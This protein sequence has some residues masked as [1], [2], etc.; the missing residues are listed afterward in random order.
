MLHTQRCAVVTTYG[1]I[2][3]GACANTKVRMLVSAIE[4]QTDI[5]KRGFED[6][7][8]MKKM[9]ADNMPKLVSQAKGKGGQ[10]KVALTKAEVGLAC[11]CALRTNFQHCLC[12]TLLCIP[13]A[14]HVQSCCCV[15]LYCI[16]V[17]CAESGL[18]GGSPSPPGLQRVPQHQPGEGRL[19]QAAE[20]LAESCPWLISARQSHRRSHLDESTGLCNLQAVDTEMCVIK[21]QSMDRRRDVLMRAHEYSGCSDVAL[22][23]DT[24]RKRL[25]E[26]VREYDYL[27][28][29]HADLHSLGVSKYPQGLLS[30][31]GG[32]W[33]AAQPAEGVSSQHDYDLSGSYAQLPLQACSLLS[34]SDLHHI[35]TGWWAASTQCQ[36]RFH[37]QAEP[38]D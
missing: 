17:C 31:C 13:A 6:I 11:C 19:A 36:H 18:P 5:M 29:A 35:C 3:A 4:G 32:C 10:E 2:F 28:A 34:E 33:E 7:A 26:V 23:Y 22:I 8:D 27:M 24:L 14:S 25:G 1:T 20:G 12:S 16:A 9:W 38:P 30:D 37:F 15:P 21:R